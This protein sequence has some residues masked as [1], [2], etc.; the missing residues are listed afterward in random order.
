M[1]LRLAYCR[2][3]LCAVLAVIVFGMSGSACADSASD[4]D[5]SAFVDVTEAVVVPDVA[6]RNQGVSAVQK[7]RWNR[8]VQLC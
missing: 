6:V 8:Q 2:Q 1:A 4:A 3:T 7:G 5:R